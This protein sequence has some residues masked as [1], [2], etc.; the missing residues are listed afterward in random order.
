MGHGYRAEYPS[1]DDE[2]PTCCAEVLSEAIEAR[3]RTL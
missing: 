2:I 1:L 3:M